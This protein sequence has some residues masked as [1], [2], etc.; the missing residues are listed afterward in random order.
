MGVIKAVKLPS[1]H[2]TYT[3]V[4]TIMAEDPSMLTTDA[5]KAKPWIA[6]TETFRDV[7][8]PCICAVRWLCRRRIWLAANRFRHGYF[9]FPVDPAATKARE[10]AS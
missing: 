2:G 1:G 5:E 9:L 6:N 8:Y 3:T 10:A 4:S 7:Y